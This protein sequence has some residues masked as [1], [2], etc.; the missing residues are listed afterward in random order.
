VVG[1]CVTA[2][3]VLVSAGEALWAIPLLFWALC[4]GLVVQLQMVPRPA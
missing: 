4:V 1:Y 3:A 2:T